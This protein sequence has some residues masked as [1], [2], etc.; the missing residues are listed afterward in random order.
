[1]ECEVPMTIALSFLVFGFLISVLTTPWV[2]RIAHQGIGMDAPTEGRK[3]QEK[4]VPRLGGMP[5]MLALSL[6][7]ILILLQEQDKASDWFPILVGSVLMYALG[8]CD[9]I[10][11]IGAKK[12]LI[13]Q[14]AIASL[15]YSLGLSIDKFSIPQIGQIELGGWSAPVTIFWLIAIPNIVNLIDGFDGLAGGLGL[16]MALTMG[17]VGYHSQHL[18][19]TWFSFTLAGTLL[20]FLVY[21]FPPAKIYLGDGGAYLI[22]FVIGS[23]SISSAHKGSVAAGLVVTVV[24]LGLPILDTSFALLRRAFRGFPLFHADDDHFHHRLERLGFSKGRIL[25]GLYSICAVLSVIGL[26]VVWNQDPTIPLVVGLGV[27]FLLALAVI[28]H[29]HRVKTWGDAHRKVARVLSRRAENRYALLQAKVLVIEIERCDSAEEFWAV[30]N[31]TMRRVGFVEE[32]E[33]LD[34]IRIEI[35]HNGTK[36][37]VLHAPRREGTAVEWKRI[38]EVF[39]PVFVSARDKWKRQ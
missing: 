8:L 39:R 3:N 25:L 29:F 12:K 37:W 23:L 32:G 35:K 7:L 11:P 34:E 10:K 18:A 27:F 5:I 20:G 33:V 15:V 28:R 36:P 2:I 4:P 13:G 17:V 31:D 9:D 26:M 30:F 24:G 19:L 21:N 6:A 22:G 38:A 14:I 16:F 1:M